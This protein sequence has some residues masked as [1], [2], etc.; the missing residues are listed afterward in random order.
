[1]YG[2]RRACSSATIAVNVWLPPL[3]PGHL[4]PSSPTAKKPRMACACACVHVHVPAKKLRMA[5]ELAHEFTHELA[6][7]FTHELA[8]AFTHELAHAFTH[9]LAHEITHELAHA[10][11]HELAHAFTHELAHELARGSGVRSCAFGAETVPGDAAD[12]GREAG[13]RLDLT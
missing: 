3:I 13:I 1:M 4:S 6:H 8:H 11:T 5:H 9:E 10:F 12:D 2:R 7:E